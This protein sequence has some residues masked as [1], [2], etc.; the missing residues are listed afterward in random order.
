MSEWMCVCV[1]VCMSSFEKLKRLYLR[2]YLIGCI[3]IW[4]GIKGEASLSVSFPLKLI[5][6]LRFYDI[7][8]FVKNVM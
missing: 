6:G 4:Y 7:L 5:H 1:C 2:N 8:N 3:E